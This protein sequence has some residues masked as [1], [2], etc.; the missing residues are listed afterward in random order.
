MDKVKVALLPSRVATRAK[1]LLHA[2]KHWIGVMWLRAL[3][4]SCEAGTPQGLASA[5]LQLAEV[6]AAPRGWARPSF[7]S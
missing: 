1:K 2:N 6:N 7:L 3:D 5:A 4:A